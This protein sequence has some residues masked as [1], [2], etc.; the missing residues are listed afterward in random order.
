MREGKEGERG[1]EERER[2]REETQEI[3]GGH[4]TCCIGV[5]TTCSSCTHMCTPT[6][7][8]RPGLPPVPHEPIQVH[9]GALC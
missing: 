1:K 6:Q 4:S 5:D 2:K 7:L 9:L 8:R 3:C